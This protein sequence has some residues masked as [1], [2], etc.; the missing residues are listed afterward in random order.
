MRQNDDMI[1]EEAKN[2]C[3]DAFE[4]L[5]KKY[6]PIVLNQRN[7]YHLRDFD[8]DDWLQE[9]RIVCYQ[10]LEKYDAAKNVT[11]GL[12]FKINFE[13]HTISLLRHQEA[14]KRQIYRH[15]DYIEGLKGE[16]SDLVSEDYKAKTSLE[17]I[18]VRETLEDFSTCLSN[19]EMQIYYGLLLGDNLTDI[20]KK[21]EVSPKKIKCGYSRI[22]QKIKKQILD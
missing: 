11:F 14:Q 20:S 5:F 7:R 10:S 6:L 17:Y 9:G 19:F 15:T 4:S 22:K 8:L 21:L 12:F 16:T 2:G 1:I 13:R 18:L 3:S